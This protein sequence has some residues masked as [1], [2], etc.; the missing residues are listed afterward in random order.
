MRAA[1]LPAVRPM[2]AAPPVRG[3]DEMITDAFGAYPGS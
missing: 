1:R 2:R 3:S